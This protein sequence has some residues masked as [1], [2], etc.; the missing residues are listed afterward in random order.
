M[1]GSIIYGFIIIIIIKTQQW[2]RNI[3]TWKE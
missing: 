3:G 1:K 2:T